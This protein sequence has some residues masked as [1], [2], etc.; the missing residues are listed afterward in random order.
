[1]N[2]LLA[3]IL[4]FTS[5]VSYSQQDSRVRIDS[6]NGNKITVTQ[7]GKDSAQKSELEIAGS[8]TNSADI[9]QI[10]KI[11]SKQ[12]NTSKFSKWISNANNVI[13]LFS[14]L[15]GLVLLIWK[16]KRIFKK[17]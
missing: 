10:E 5:L 8:D 4:I 9:Y 7:T 2:K 15:A 11:N 12:E 1:M 6:S 16:L 13:I 17:K 14:S 3:I